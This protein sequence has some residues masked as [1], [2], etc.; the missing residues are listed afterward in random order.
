MLTFLAVKQALA[1]DQ[2]RGCNGVEGIVDGIVGYP[3]V[4][5]EGLGSPPQSYPDTTG[6][7]YTH[8]ILTGRLGH[9]GSL[10]VKP[11]SGNHHA[12][13]LLGLGQVE[14]S[15]TRHLVIAC[16]AGSPCSPHHHYRK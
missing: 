16:V 5:H 12:V 6:S 3:Y 8:H 7:M 14:R 10:P 1:V 4:A 9:G 15:Q 13:W 2:R 11:F